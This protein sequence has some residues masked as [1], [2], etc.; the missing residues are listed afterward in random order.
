[1]ICTQCL[2][3]MA[4]A[5]KWD[6]VDRMLR[7]LD[8]P[9][10]IDKWTRLYETHKEH[11]LSAY[12]NLIADDH[13]TALSWSDENERW[14]IIKEQG[15]FDENIK[16]VEDAKRR[17]LRK[18]WSSDYDLEDLLWLDN[19]YNMILNSQNVSTPILQERAK[20][21]CELELR[22][23]K[24]LRAGL[25][26][27]KDMDA[28]DNI[29][30]LHKFDASNSKNT[31]DFE[32][33]GELGVYLENRGW[34]PSWHTEPNDSID[35]LMRAIQQYNQRLIEAEPTI[36]DRLEANRER[37]NAKE[38]LEEM[39]SDE[40]VIQNENPDTY[41]DEEGLAEDLNVWTS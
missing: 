20:D 9:F 39:G 22:V 8:L 15:E 10:D 31:A 17:E 26:V 14:R 32:S 34:H 36:K 28:C 27:K 23:K 41:E 25:D 4:P 12:L 38:R 29:I 11:T 16:V 37:Y 18:R 33:F 35:F 6:E 5:D 7:Y 21:L 24:G 40:F 2:E 1:M 19:F 3:K 30:K 13:Y